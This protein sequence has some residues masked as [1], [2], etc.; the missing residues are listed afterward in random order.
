MVKLTA[1]FPS[2]W[3][4]SSRIHQRNSGGQQGS[5]PTKIQK[6][7]PISDAASLRPDLPGFDPVKFSSWQWDNKSHDLVI[8]TAI[9]K[10]M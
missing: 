4:P 2:F 5:S 7:I 10:F 6:P 3:G 8:N 9:Y 1:W